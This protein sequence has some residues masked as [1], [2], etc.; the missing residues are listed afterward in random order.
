VEEREPR[1]VAALEAVRVEQLLLERR[2]EALGDGVR[3]RRRGGPMLGKI[4]AC[5]IVLPNARLV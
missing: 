4:P 1:L 3:R 2:E 5:C